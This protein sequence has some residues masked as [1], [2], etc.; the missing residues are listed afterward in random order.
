[1]ADNAAKGRRRGPGRP[2][3][4]GKSGNPAGNRSG[5][6]PAALLALDE[7]AAAD[8]AEILRGILNRAK[9]GDAEAT[10]LV[11]ARLWPPRRG[12]P[13][14]MPELAQAATAEDAFRALLAAVGRG[15]VSP[16][17]GEA[18][19]NLIAARRRWAGMPERPGGMEREAAELLGFPLS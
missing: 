3:G 17:E 1:M 7:M 16:E 13:V 8:A 10:A 11:M 14:H 2:F 19:A 12:R 4:P 9:M 5:S 15:E 18:I 6:R